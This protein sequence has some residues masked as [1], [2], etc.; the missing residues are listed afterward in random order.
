M[1]LL[2]EEVRTL[3]QEHLA[4]PQQQRERLIFKVLQQK[5]YS[6][7]QILVALRE[8]KGTPVKIHK[9]ELKQTSILFEGCQQDNEGNV[10]DPYSLE[11]IPDNY[12][13]SY[14]SNNQKFCFDK[15]SL[16]RQYTLTGNII[17]PFTRIEFPQELTKEV[18]SFGKQLRKVAVFGDREVLLEPFSPLGEII[19]LLLKEI[20]GSLL[21]NIALINPHYKNRSL[22]DFDLSQADYSIFMDKRIVINLYPFQNLTEKS[23]LLI[24]LFNFAKMNRSDGIYESVYTYLG[25]LLDIS[26]IIKL[27]EGYDFVV[28]PQLKVIDIVKQF[29]EALSS[30]RAIQTTDIVTEQGI[31][32]SSLDLNKNVASQIPGEQLYHVA[33]ADLDE[34]NIVIRRYARYA[35]NTNDKMLQEAIFSG[36]KAK[37]FVFTYPGKLDPSVVSGNY[38]FNELTNYLL[39][40]VLQINTNHAYDERIQNRLEI[41]TTRN[42][43]IL[44]NEL[45][46]AAIG[47]NDIKNVIRTQYMLNKFLETKEVEQAIKKFDLHSMMPSIRN[48]II[49]IIAPMFKGN[50]FETGIVSERYSDTTVAMLDDVSLFLQ[51]KTDIKSVIIK[52]VVHGGNK[53]LKYARDI[54]NPVIGFWGLMYVLTQNELDVFLTRLTK[55]QLNAIVEAQDFASILTSLDT[56]QYKT[57]ILKLLSN[58]NLTPET[59][60]ITHWWESPVIIMY[61]ELWLTFHFDNWALALQAAR[62][63]NVERKYLVLVA[64]RLSD[65]YTLKSI[66]PDSQNLFLEAGKVVSIKQPEK[67]FALA[68]EYEYMFLLQELYNNY[69]IPTQL[70]I[71]LLDTAKTKSERRRISEFPR[72]NYD[73]YK[74]ILNR[75]FLEQLEFHAL[76]LEYFAEYL[77]KEAS[78][79][80]FMQLI[81]TGKCALHELYEYAL[82][83]NFNGDRFNILAQVMNRNCH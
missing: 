25:S 27:N 13:V 38:I 71:D 40:F 37:G 50:F 12:L 42:A 74:Q 82:T 83:H 68:V 69:D 52:S 6:N 2:T 39:N 62:N 80:E 65:E 9:T 4:L 56:K 29:Y 41:L 77:F 43:F 21:D 19:L 11:P 76:P 24:R 31:S 47:T 44:A 22:Y 15:R 26:P 51:T 66:K 16:Y 67:T 53:I 17:N 64:K 33:Y 61:P 58:S 49:H 63:A 73:V 48:H 3:L 35:F 14:I 72:K 54:L 18:I 1:S 28:N 70:L 79:N 60:N 34:R 78:S 10:V 30:L 55:T 20:E 23:E 8:A 46:V 32:L 7:G 75:A 45:L 5:G 59:L 81:N 57:N 36:T